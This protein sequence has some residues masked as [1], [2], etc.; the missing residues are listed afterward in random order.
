MFYT[1][2]RTDMTQLI[3]AFRNFAKAPKKF[4]ACSQIIVLSLVFI[5]ETGREQEKSVSTSDMPRI[6][7]PSRLEV[8]VQPTT[9]RNLNPV[10]DRR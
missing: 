1:D 8:G 7:Q 6:N 5:S 3:M 4:V 9:S 10:L 2:G